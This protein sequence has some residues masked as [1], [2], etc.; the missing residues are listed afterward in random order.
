MSTVDWVLLAGV[1]ASM[2]L[3]AWRGLVSGL[4]S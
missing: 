1:L 2:L 4:R 3:G